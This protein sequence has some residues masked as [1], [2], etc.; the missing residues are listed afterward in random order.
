MTSAAMGM[1]SEKIPSAATLAN[2]RSFVGKLSTKR[3]NRPNSS[4][5]AH[6]SSTANQRF[7]GMHDCNV[8][9]NMATNRDLGRRIVT[10]AGSV[11]ARVP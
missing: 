6:G 10:S 11:I 7:G 2:A 1:T 3:A 8:Y 5:P 4:A 9:R